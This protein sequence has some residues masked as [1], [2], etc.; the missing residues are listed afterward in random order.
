MKERRK[1]DR[2]RFGRSV[3]WLGG[4]VELA[5]K[6]AKVWLLILGLGCWGIGQAQD[7][8]FSQFHQSPLS[9]NP[10][11]TG[12]ITEDF[13][14]TANYRSQWESVTVPFVTMA[15]SVD[16][17]VLQGFLDDDFF[18]LGLQLINDKA[19]DSEFKNTGVH[20]SAAYSKSLNGDGNHFLSF[21]GQFGG[22]QRSL[23]F[24]NLTFDS[25]FDGDVLN[26][27]LGSGES[28]DR[29]SRFYL[30]FGAG[31]T[32]F[33]AP[34]S[35]TS[36]YIGAAM[37]HLNRANVSFFNETDELLDR[38]ATLHA[39]AEF[40]ING[41]VSVLPQ[42]V[43]LV[44]G[45]HREI[46]IGSLIKYN[47]NPDPDSE[48]NRF[49]LALGGLYR[50]AD[51]AIAV[52]KIEWGPIGIGFSYDFNV[53]S[54]SVASNGRGGPEVSLIYTGSFFQKDIRSRSGPVNC[55]WGI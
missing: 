21:G 24:N 7:A 30:D 38:K 20:L 34:Y 32:W 46:N 22:V 28:L 3:V 40:G 13:R 48:L 33:Y 19:G 15:A 39:G 53:S 49:A 29:T 54:L 11:M 44:Q 16:I 5:V 26:T 41:F 36:F 37:T 17:S 51:A 35:N 50:F 45:P 42:A 18:G 1:V 47:F 25:Q 9:L 6:K 52:V 8:H 31:L 4:S 12:L 14:F 2:N 23:N 10:A 55:P 43:V 27:D